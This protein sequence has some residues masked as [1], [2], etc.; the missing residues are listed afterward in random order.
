MRLKQADL[1]V[2]SGKKSSGV[3]PN[4]NRQN[5]LRERLTLVYF[6]VFCWGFLKQN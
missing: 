5:H 6:K 1:I 4:K 2:L 3:F